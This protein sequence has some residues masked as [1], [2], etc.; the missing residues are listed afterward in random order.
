[1]KTNNKLIFVYLQG[2]VIMYFFDTVGKNIIEVLMDK[3]INQNE[4]A[5]EIGVS[6]VVMSKIV[7]GQKAVNA[8]EIRKIAE[9]LEVNIDRLVEGKE[10]NIDQSIFSFM[11]SVNDKNKK[12]LEFLNS[13]I[14]EIITLEEVL[15]G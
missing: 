4:L 1:M 2:G 12:E 11:E 15:N 9:V 13:I 10:D 3:D 5:D 8:L 6:K 7:K 14:G